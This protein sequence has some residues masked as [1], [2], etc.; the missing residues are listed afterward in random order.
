MTSSLVRTFAIAVV[1]CSACGK[2]ESSDD[3]GPVIDAVLPEGGHGLDASP[4]DGP[5]SEVEGPTCGAV[6][7]QNGVEEC[8]LTATA[9]CRRA[10]TCTT[11]A[12]ACDGP[13]DCNGGSCC[14]PTVGG[15]VCGASPNCETA[16][17]SDLNCGPDAP[18]CCSKPGTP[19]YFV[20]QEAC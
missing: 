10:G 14:Y 7:C 12:F 19:N 20:C 18:S 15:S 8:C 17:H 11:A 5:R 4:I 2:S 13:E 9:T 6:Q 3:M 16:C 1:A